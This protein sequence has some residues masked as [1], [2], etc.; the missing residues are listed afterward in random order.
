MSL[1]TGS[2]KGAGAVDYNTVTDNMRY[3]VGAEL[4]LTMVGMSL[5]RDSWS[6][7]EFGIRTDYGLNYLHFFGDSPSDR[8]GL[9]GTIVFMRWV[10]MSAGM[11]FEIGE[12]GGGSGSGGGGGYS[13]VG[14][15]FYSSTGSGSGEP[16][17]FWNLGLLNLGLVLEPFGTN[18]KHFGWYI[19]PEFTLGLGYKGQVKFLFDGLAS[20]G[21]RYTF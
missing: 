13:G 4:S 14:E 3:G 8:F 21:I 16:Q 10:G 18:L 5:D 1:L 19:N 12:S 7:T 15:D 2:V 17:T 20:T 9:K 11:F 6:N